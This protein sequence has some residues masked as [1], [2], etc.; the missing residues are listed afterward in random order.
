[1][2]KSNIGLLVTS[3]PTNTPGRRVTVDFLAE[4]GFGMNV[5]TDLMDLLMVL[6]LDFWIFVDNIFSFYEFIS[7]FDFILIFPH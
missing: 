5:C 2:D 7:D 3:G 1:M 4:P 6:K